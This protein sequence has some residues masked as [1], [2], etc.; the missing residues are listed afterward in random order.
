MLALQA[1]V[2]ELT[3]ID[4]GYILSA[5]HILHA[6][7]VFL[8]TERIAMLKQEDLHIR[9]D[10]YIM[11][12]YTEEDIDVKRICAYF[13]I[14]KTYLYKISRQNY[15][16]GIAEHIRNLRI[17]KAKTL[18]AKHTYTNVADVAYECGFE[19]Y[20]YF[21]TLFKNIVGVSPGQYRKDQ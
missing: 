18:L 20:N 3:V 5:S 9:I 6:V 21:F 12:H 7:A 16:S 15:G 10:K 11:A 19:D 13:K 2:G 4:E 8:R 1:A 14:G 17:E